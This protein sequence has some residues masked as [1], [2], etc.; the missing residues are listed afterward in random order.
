MLRLI[1]LAGLLVSSSP[2]TAE[3]WIVSVTKKPNGTIHKVIQHIP[4]P[5][6]PGPPPA[7][8]RIDITI[9]RLPNGDRQVTKTVTNAKGTLTTVEIREATH[10]VHRKN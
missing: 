6:L 9:K 2:L 7:P 8:T 5:P 10:A 1:L 4:D 3:Q